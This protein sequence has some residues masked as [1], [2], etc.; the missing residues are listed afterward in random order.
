MFMNR[1]ARLSLIAVVV[2]VAATFGCLVPHYSDDGI[3]GAGQNVTTTVTPSSTGGAGVGGACSPASPC[4]DDG[5]PCTTKACV[6]GFCART[7]L[8][9][10]IGPGSDKCMTIACVNG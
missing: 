5:N 4:E 1:K 6:N 8:T 9:L 3:G 2:G 10:A 7:P